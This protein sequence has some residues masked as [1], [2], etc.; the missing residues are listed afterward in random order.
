MLPILAF[1][2]FPLFPSGEKARCSGLRPLVCDSAWLSLGGGGLDSQGSK[3][4]ERM[5]P[6]I[7]GS[8]SSW[9]IFQPVLNAVPFF[10]VQLK[11][12]SRPQTQL[13]WHLPSAPDTLLSS[14]IVQSLS[15]VRLF[16]TPWTTARQASLSITISQ[17]LLRLMPIESV[18]PSNH[19]STV[20]RCKF[21][22]EVRAS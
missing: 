15:C 20:P 22:T 11:A 4:H 13:P 8:T 10:R 3:G 16:V 1:M 2:V 6:H 18:M 7:P 5:S 12:F 21:H 14:D 9:Q 17:S 19:L